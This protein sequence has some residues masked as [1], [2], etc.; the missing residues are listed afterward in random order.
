MKKVDFITVLASMCVVLVLEE[1]FRTSGGWWVDF[2]SST[3]RLEIHLAWMIEMIMRDFSTKLDDDLRKKY[4]EAT[5]FAF[6]FGC[7]VLSMQQ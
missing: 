6:V 7:R 5:T 3:H 4:R 2:I 1:D